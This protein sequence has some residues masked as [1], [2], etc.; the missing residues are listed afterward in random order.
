[1]GVV[2]Y[3][4]KILRSQNL[5]H[6]EIK[7]R[8]YEGKICLHLLQNLTSLLISKNVRMIGTESYLVYK[9]A[10]FL[11]LV[12]LIKGRIFIDF[13]EVAH[14]GFDAVNVENIFHSFCP[15]VPML[16]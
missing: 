3:L 8:Y 10:R 9:F 11:K 16:T 14:N 15:A 6:E 4:G 5:I 2:K 12:T 7:N 1:M 13:P